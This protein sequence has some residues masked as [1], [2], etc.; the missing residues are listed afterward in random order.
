MGGLVASGVVMRSAPD[1]RVDGLG[2]LVARPATILVEAVAQVRARVPRGP[3][4]LKRA[5]GFLP[6][7]RPERISGWLIVRATMT[8]SGRTRS[9][10]L[11]ETQ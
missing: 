4:A 9:P 5:Q 8:V 3:V 10:G 1:D 7:E 2:G 6:V 11:T